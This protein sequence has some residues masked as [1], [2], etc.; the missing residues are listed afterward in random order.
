VSE[1]EYVQALQ[2]RI[3]EVSPNGLP[4]QPDLAKVTV[5]EFRQCAR[6]EH[7]DVVLVVLVA[8]ERLE[9]LV[10][11]PVRGAQ[12]QEA[13]SGERAGQR[14][15]E[16]ALVLQVFDHLEASDNVEQAQLRVRNGRVSCRERD[17]LEGVLL[18]RMAYRFG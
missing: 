7:I 4:I 8:R 2:D 1:V 12:D 18:M 15:E 10:D 17:V 11:E 6:S 13:L 3:D 14:R 5:G 16:R 9:E